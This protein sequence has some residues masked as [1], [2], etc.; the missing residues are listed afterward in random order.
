MQ[1]NP[2][3]FNQYSQQQFPQQQFFFQQQTFLQQ[4]IPQQQA[5]LQQINNQMSSRYMM[6]QHQI[7]FFPQQSNSDISMLFTNIQ[8][9]ISEASKENEDN[10]P[11]VPSDI[12]MKSISSSFK[13]QNQ[14]NKTRNVEMMNISSF[15][16]E[17]QQHLHLIKKLNKSQDSNRIQSMETSSLIQKQKQNILHDNQLNDNNQNPESFKNQFFNKGT[18][19]LSNASSSIHINSFSSNRYSGNYSKMSQV[20]K[21]KQFLFNQRVKDNK[22][23]NYSVNLNELSNNSKQIELK[24]LDTQL[25]SSQQE[26]NQQELNNSFLSN[27]EFNELFSFANQNPI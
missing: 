8:E 12:K 5:F 13:G 2:Y 14:S 20:A 22:N 17:N 23:I 9:S 24:Q 26:Y 21:S 27:T 15:N 19:N 4:P 3:Y 25:S 1:G 11:E 6:Q 10:I 16:N 18:I 7:N